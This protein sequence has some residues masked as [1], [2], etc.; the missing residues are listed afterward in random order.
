MADPRGFMKYERRVAERSVGE[1]RGGPR[2]AP[3]T[4]RGNHDGSPVA[5]AAPAAVA[6]VGSTHSRVPSA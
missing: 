1:G 6:A 3:R 4:R 5:T 2:E